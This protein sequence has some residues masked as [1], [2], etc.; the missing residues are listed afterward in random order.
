MTPM[1]V[2]QQ[3]AY[4]HDGRRWLRFPEVALAPGR[5]LLVHGPSGSGKS[6]WLALV[7]GLLTPGAG[8]VFV[9]G[10]ALGRLSPAERDR[11]RGRR[12]GFL[13]QRLH[14]SAALTVAQNVEL[15]YVACGLP[16]DHAAVARVL[17]RL[18]IAGLARRRPSQLSGGQALRVALARAMVRAPALLIADEPTASLDDEACERALVL[19]ADTARTVG[20]TLVV[21]THD[22]RVA[23]AWPQA[24]VLRLAPP[25]DEGEVA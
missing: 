10:L 13:S 24:Q 7:S 1:I 9:D 2:T 5:T 8:E 12:V 25:G 14:L 3:L 19:L 11:W 20:A 21:A 6:T 4:S 23:Q 18:D 17:A 22:R 15:S 16:V